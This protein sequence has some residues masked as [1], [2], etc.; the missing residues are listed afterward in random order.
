MTSKVFYYKSLNISKSIS[1]QFFLLYYSMFEF[2]ITNDEKLD[3]NE[4]IIKIFIL[5]T[6]RNLLNK[7]TFKS[8]KIIGY[9]IFIF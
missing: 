5:M 1:S 2:K 7:N 8:I 9:L 4:Q 6:F 3:Y